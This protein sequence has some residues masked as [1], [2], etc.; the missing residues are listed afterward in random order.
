MQ[1]CAFYLT[2][3][4]HG[5]A[6][7]DSVAR[8]HL[9]NGATLERLNWLADT[10]ESGVRRS[11]GLMANYVYRLADLERNHESYARDCSVIASRQIE[12]LAKQSRLTTQTAAAR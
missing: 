7:F 1:L 8:F 5:K 4:K 9:A 2:S 3:A 6:P 11:F 12:R 10:S